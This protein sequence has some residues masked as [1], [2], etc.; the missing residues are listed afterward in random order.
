VTAPRRYTPPA[1]F[2]LLDLP[3]GAAVGYVT[4][5]VP[6]WLARAGVPAAT[7]ATV[8]ATATV[9]LWAKLLWVPLLDAGSHRKLWY[10]L[11]AAGVAGLLVALSLFDD[12]AH[13]LPAFTALL[14]AAM[15]AATTAHAALNALVA[16]TVRDDQKGKAA[17]CYMAS[18]I[19]STS[20]IGGALAPWLAERASPAASGWALAAAVAAGSAGALFIREPRLDAERPEGG[21]SRLVLHRAGAIARDLWS[22]VSS[23]EGFTGLVICLAP[24]GAGALTNLFSGLSVHYGASPDRVSLVNG[25]GGG[26]VGVLGSLLGG[27]LADRMN[28]R[29]AYALAG[30]VTALVAL[31]MLA[32]PLDAGTYTWGVLLYGFANGVAFATWAGM[33]LE[34]VRHTP[35]VATKYAL[36]NAAANVA[37]SYSVFLDGNV[38]AWMGWGEARGGLLTDAV[39]TF[40]GIGLVGAMVLSA[41]RGGVR[42][43]PAAG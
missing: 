24:V 11:S 6:L 21:V 8:I 5:A 26:A 36:F 30:G 37:S 25:V 27:L 34:M 31:A 9:P 39:L 40:A 12:P 10:L 19:G 20:L 16:V 3:Y 15:A 17:G 38:P 14:T 33:V 29:L 43:A 41:R 4:I 13:H 32:A 23:R 42:R 18:N 22:T 2:L 7:Y 28:R 1:L 35:G